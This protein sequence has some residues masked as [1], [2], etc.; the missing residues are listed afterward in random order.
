MR[1]RFVRR[2]AIIVLTIVGFVIVLP[3]TIGQQPARPLPQSVQQAGMTA[4]P[5]VPPGQSL[6]DL[7]PVAQEILRSARGGTEWLCRAHQANGRFLAGW[8]PDLNLPAD[9]DHFLRQ[10]GATLALA[11]SARLFR[12]ERYAAHA[13]QAI[14]TL[15]AET[16]PDPADPKARCTTLPSA[17]VN[18][19]GAAG[20][21]LATICELPDPAPDLLDQ[22]EQLA[23]FIAHRQQPD[24]SFRC[25]DTPEEPADPDAINRHPGPA[26]YGLMRSQALRPVPWKAEAARKAL[27]YYRTWWRDDKHK[28]AT[29]ADWQSAAFAEAFMQSKSWTAN[30]QPDPAYAAFAFE[31]C[32]GLCALQIRDLDVRHPHWRGGFADAVTGKA[33]PAAPTAGGATHALAVVEACRVTRQVPDAERYA[34]YR[35]S[36]YGAMQFLTTLQYTEAN[37][38]HFSAGY[39]QQ[40]LLGGFHTSHED[41]T[42][43][44]EHTEQAV[45]ALTRYWEFV[46]APE[47]ASQK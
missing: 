10:A 24:G 6:A 16:G 19:L 8:V 25:T 41:G 30:R 5:N 31:M 17:V 14:L 43:H 4:P 12:D 46:V 40:M 32:D 3:G 37:T 36:A 27:G 7:P 42:L 28:Q 20:L 13:R 35:D 44:L 23:V 1:T 45:A 47:L 38:Q 39:R 33:M 15:L 9:G 18:R 2:L 29:F 22:G 11:R 34:R 21:L 26:L